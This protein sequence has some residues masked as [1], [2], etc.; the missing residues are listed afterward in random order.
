MSTVQFTETQ[1]T[2]LNRFFT[3]CSGSIMKYLT[4]GAEDDGVEPSEL[5]DKIQ[6]ILTTKEFTIMSS[7]SMKNKKMKKKTTSVEEEIEETDEEKEEVTVKK[8]KTK[9][10]TKTKAKKTKTNTKKKGSSG[11]TGHRLYMFGIKDFEAFSGKI[12]EFKGSD[13]VEE[14]GQDKSNGEIHKHCFS[15]ASQSW[16]DANQDEWKALAEEVK[17]YWAESMEGD[18]EEDKKFSWED[19]TEEQKHEF[20]DKANKI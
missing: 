18:D 9:T 17:T 11:P 15:L 14:W 19:F 10:K 7:K 12:V 20:A 13:E 2:H 16:K 5:K 3:E 8:T 1:I 6:T 4:E